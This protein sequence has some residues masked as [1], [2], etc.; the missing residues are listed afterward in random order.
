M[1]TLMDDDPKEGS[2]VVNTAKQV[3]A[4]VFSGKKES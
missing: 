2:V 3:M 1:R 4:S